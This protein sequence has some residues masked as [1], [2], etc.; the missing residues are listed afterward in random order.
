MKNK[1]N[2]KNTLAIIAGVLFTGLILNTINEISPKEVMSMN[3]AIYRN[4]EEETIKYLDTNEIQ[5]KI[6]EE[7]INVQDAEYVRKVINV[8]TYLERRGAPLA[9]YAERIC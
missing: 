4:S 6:L 8:R 5:V 3:Q 1:L 2:K 7:G 9:A